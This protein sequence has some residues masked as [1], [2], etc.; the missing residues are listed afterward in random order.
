MKIKELFDFEYIQRVVEIGKIKDEQEMV[1]RFVISNNLE[2]D[3]LEFLEYIKGNRKEDNISINVIGNYGT[4]KSHLLAFISLILSKPELI[5]YIQSEKVKNEFRNLN[6]DFLVIKY[7]LP[8]IKHKS[9]ASIFFY[10]VKK[11]LKEN[12]GIELRSIDLEKDE[13]DSKELVEE[14]LL[15]IKEKYPTSG[16]IVIFDEFSDF[17]KQKS[18]VDR[19]FD[20]MFAKQLAECSIDSDFILMISMQ[21]HIFSNPEFMDNAELISRIDKRFLKINITSENVE[22]IIANRIVKK[23][24]NQIQELKKLFESLKSR[25]SNLSLEEERYIQLFPVHPYIIEIFSKLPY[26]ENRSILQF[27]SYEISKILD[28]EFPSFVTFDLIYDEM[29]EADHNVKNHPDVKPVVEIVNSLENII[30]RIKSSYRDRG[31]KLVK[32]LAVLNLIGSEDMEGKRRGGENANRLAQNLFMLP[33]SSMIAPENDIETIFGMIMEESEGQF[34]SKKNDVYFISTEGPDYWQIIDLKAVNRDDLPLMNERFVENFLLDELGIEF[35]RDIIYWD[36]SKKY[37]LDDSVNWK[38]RNSFREGQL[39]IYVGYNLQMGESKDYVLNFMGYPCKEMDTR[40]QKNII[41]HPVYNKDLV[42]N[43]KRLDAIEEFI[44]ERTHLDAMRNIKRRLIDRELKEGF[45]N[46]LKN[47]IIEYKGKKFGL[48]ELGVFSEIN[49]DIFGQIKENLLGEDLTQEYPEYPRFKS[50]ISAENIK[51]TV[52]SILKDIAKKEGMVKDLLNQST[53]ILIPLGLYRG[54]ML[55]VIDSAYAN[56]IIKKLDSDSINISIPEVIQNL[57]KSPYG[58]Q[59]ELTYLIIAVLLRNGNIMISSS[60]GKL[61]TSSDFYEL[62]HSGLSSFES[63]KYI[64]KGVI[65]V[66]EAKLLFEALNIDNSLLAMERDHPAAY[67][68]YMEKIENIERDIISIKENFESLKQSVDIGL[69]ISE[70]NHQIM[71]IENLDMEKLRIKNLT[72]LN[73]L[74]YS[75]ERLEEIKEGYNLIKT[76]KELLKDCFDFI[77]TGINYMEN[78]ME[79]VENDCFKKSDQDKL[80]QIHQDSIEIVKDIR[81]ILKEDE[82]KPLKGKIDQFKD[83]YKDIYYQSHKEMVGTGV[84]WGYID[85]I[86]HSREFEELIILKDV[87]SIPSTS[88][89]EIRLKIMELKDLKCTD[90][91]VD[92]LDTSYHCHCMFPMGNYD[93]NINQT[94]KKVEEDVEKLDK[95]WKSQIFSDI[96]QNQDRLIQLDNHEKDVISSVISSGQLPSEIDHDFVRVVNNLLTPIS[97]VEINFNDLYVQLKNE[98]DFFKVNEFRKVLESYLNKKL[99]NKD[100][101]EIRII[102]S[103]A[104]DENSGKNE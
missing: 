102:L 42:W 21:E 34:I 46:A 45:S 17:I 20:L 27:V 19:Q 29:I 13:K 6:R 64:S 18:N 11:Q 73:K 28:N 76:I 51:G 31:L 49:S 71:K 97:F 10:R 50:K 2:E 15:K 68:S 22:D 101:K 14:I 1:E 90:F 96:K 81:K 32:S 69:P 38:D 87:N 56:I 35:K 62:F 78:A 67:K 75:Q 57:Q 94:I 91:R 25:F 39:A 36:K 66:P 74:D 95:N 82:R 88:F 98:K 7:E 47:S 12:Y 79:W 77:L 63:I 33:N 54:G 103:N 59:E 93:P 99:S 43:M 52:E 24:P 4:G 23:N 70:L 92:E 65:V 60:H 5:E 30:S 100:S 9:L 44:K 48:E 58:L 16:L 84:D 89:T 37:I 80:K 26:F 61:Y 3:I 104:F 83:K 72:E 41:I 85:K 8:A 55:D 86:E 53:N 40:H